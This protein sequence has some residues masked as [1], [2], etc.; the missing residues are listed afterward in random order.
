MVLPLLITVIA[1]PKLT[2]Y[3]YMPM[4]IASLLYVIPQGVNQALFSEGS[5]DEADLK[6]HAISSI[7]L[8]FSLL[9]PASIAL[10]VLG[11]LILRI[12]GS[13]YETEGYTFLIFLVI[14]GS[15]VSLNYVFESVFKVRKAFRTIVS[16]AVMQDIVIL[17]LS[18]ALLK[19]GLIG[20]GIAWLSG[21]ALVTITNVAINFY[22]VAA[23]RMSQSPQ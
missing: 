9:I 7:K 16:I 19:Y 20:V 5:H 8:I 6:K 22:R 13:Q 12:F 15:F 4:M 23:P 17:G 3:Y 18:V 14:S 11:S 10:I 1:S 2:A 21:Q